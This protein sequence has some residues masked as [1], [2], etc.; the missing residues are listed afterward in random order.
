MYEHTSNGHVD[1]LLAS[2][3][4]FARSIRADRA[5]PKIQ[6][7]ETCNRH[8]VGCLLV[9]RDYPADRAAPLTEQVTEW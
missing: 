7:Q 3:K 8:I 5:G 6:N 2:V 9:M 1:R 4:G